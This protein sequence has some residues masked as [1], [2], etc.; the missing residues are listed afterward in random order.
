VKLLNLKAARALVR[1]QHAAGP[2]WPYVCAAPFLA[3]AL[4]R[5][6]RLGQ[7]SEALVKAMRALPQHE[8]AA[9]FLD[10]PAGETLPA[11]AQLGRLGFLV[12][13]V[14]QR[15]VVEAAVLPGED[16]QAQL[17]G[18]APPG[19]PPDAGRGVVF[20]LDGERAGPSAPAPARRFDNRYQYPICRFPPPD[21]L[22][23]YGVRRVYWLSALPVAEDLVPYARLLADGGLAPC[24][25]PFV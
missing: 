20:L 3:A 10:L 1:W 25:F 22:R 13:P 7:P 16:L 2:Y 4:A 17:V 15:W 5:R 23:R 24:A 18:H 19:R 14:I 9:V 21:F 12:V 6:G 8:R 11:T